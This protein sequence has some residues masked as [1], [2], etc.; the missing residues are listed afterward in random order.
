MLIFYLFKKRMNFSFDFS[1][2]MLTGN[3]NPQAMVRLGALFG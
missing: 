2:A 1:G 3:I